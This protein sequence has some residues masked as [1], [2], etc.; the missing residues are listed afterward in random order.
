MAYR[1]DCEIGA[2][3]YNTEDSLTLVQL[4]ENLEEAIKKHGAKKVSEM[5]SSM[6]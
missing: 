6:S 1:I 5:L 2:I 4:M 3:T